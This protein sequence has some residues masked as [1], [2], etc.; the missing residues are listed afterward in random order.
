M[1]L[2]RV[3]HFHASGE[4]VL[5]SGKDCV[6]V[7]FSGVLFVSKTIGYDFLEKI[8]VEPLPCN[9]SIYLSVEQQLLLSLSA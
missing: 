9:P 5:W 7:L 8:Q 1:F 3:S 2:L 6:F 4:Q